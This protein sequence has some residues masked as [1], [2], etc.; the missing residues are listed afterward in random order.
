MN[1]LPIGLLLCSLAFAAG[2]RDAGQQPGVATG[3]AEPAAGQ[4]AASDAGQAADRRLRSDRNCLRETGSRIVARDN[5][6]VAAGKAPARGARCVS[7]HGRSYGRDDL[8]RTGG[9]DVADALRR[10]DPSIN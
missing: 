8:D 5:A 10:L 3:D 2:A 4:A 1:R 9:M 7:A 6:R